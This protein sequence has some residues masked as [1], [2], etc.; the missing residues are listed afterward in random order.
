MMHFNSFNKVYEFLLK[1]KYSIV[2]SLSVYDN[3]YNI[4]LFVQ[5]DYS[6]HKTRS[7]HYILSTSSKKIMASSN[8]FIGTDVLFMLFE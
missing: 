7:S 1:F 2:V 8:F 6:M 3:M 5:H 4:P